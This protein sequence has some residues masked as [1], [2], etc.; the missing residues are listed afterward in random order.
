MKTALFTDEVFR[1]FATER[2]IATAVQ[3]ALRRLLDPKIVDEVF[4]KNADQQYERSLLFSALTHL[5]S[6]VVLGNYASVNAGYKKFA[7]RLGVALNS[8]YE[9]L[10]RVE[11]ETSRKLV[12]ASYDQAVQVRRQLGGVAPHD[13]PG[14]TTRIL[15]GNHLS[16]T[17]HRLAETRAIQAAPLPGKSLVV[18]DPRFD[19]VADVFAIEDGHAQERSALDKVIETLERRQLWIADRNFCTLKFLYAIAAKCGAFVIRQHGQLHGTERGKLK[20]IGETETGIVYENRLEL[21]TYDGET[22]IVRRLVVHLFK[23]TRDADVE[24]VLLTN[25]PLEDADAMTVSELYRTRWKIETAFLHITVAMNCEI[26]ALCYPK[27]AL[28]CFANALIAYNALSI[29]KGTIAVEHGRPASDMMS[30]YYMA[31]EISETTDGLLI[32]LPDA[33]WDEVATLSVP[34]FVDEL[35]KICHGIN[36]KTYRKSTRGPKKPPPK[37]TGNKRTVHVS[38]KRILDKRK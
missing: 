34:A 3:L 15:D 11:P 22:M 23:E 16:K 13:V 27:A 25:L 7:N 38:T 6:G 29:V 2:P 12:Q 18:F 5:V 36:L 1:R 19:A 24:I 35:R 30:H 14:Y 31:L 9:K 33:R 32:A 37:R 20:K 17:E 28:F 10:K 21:P 26:N 8:V 4:R